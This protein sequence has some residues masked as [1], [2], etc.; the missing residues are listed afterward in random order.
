M[1]KI[2]L[3]FSV[4]VFAA[5]FG[6]AAATAWA[7][8]KV[9]Y[10][11]KNNRWDNAGNWKPTGVPGK[12]DAV[13]IEKDETIFIRKAAEVKSLYAL[14]GTLEI[15][16]GASL[17]VSRQLTLDA[18]G[19]RAA[20]LTVKD[21]GKLEISR[22]CELLIYDDEDD[23]DV[24]AILTVEPDG[25]LINDGR[26][27]NY[28]RIYNE[29]AIWNYGMIKNF[30]SAGV[31]PY[32][33][34]GVIINYYYASPPCKFYSDSHVAH[35]DPPESV[36]RIPETEQNV[37]DA[38]YKFYYPIAAAPEFV[39]NIQADINGFSG[40]PLF[41]KPE[42]DLVKKY[43]KEKSNDI[44]G[45]YAF[46][47][48]KLTPASP[49]LLGAGLIFKIRP[50]NG[51]VA[52]TPPEGLEE[53]LANFSLNKVFQ[54]GNVYDL[55]ELIGKCE[56]AITCDYDPVSRDFTLKV[57]AAITVIDGPVPDDHKDKPGVI[58]V[59]D[60]GC[61]V[62]YD[63]EKNVLLI[64]DGKED[65]VIADPIVLMKKEPK[66]GGGGCNTGFLP[67]LLALAIVVPFVRRRK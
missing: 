29:G 56:G 62:Y 21:G 59:G 66:K 45:W 9:W 1:K 18:Y 32:P 25:E 63:E 40:N 58:P 60:D 51:G 26:I 17:S 35:V 50:D 37:E 55:L 33:D 30:Y 3:M 16:T 67:G 27:E 49:V 13:R 38:L 52:V 15:N 11:S 4:W 24:F 46:L 36:K 28:G 31:Y 23:P 14:R 43:L 64:F 6:G 57:N 47:E 44:I 20:K 41:D 8:T 10:G 65:G 53:L 39:K 22:G 34:K 5:A 12:N 48:E 42:F 61:A 7:E 54:T 2:F 19:G